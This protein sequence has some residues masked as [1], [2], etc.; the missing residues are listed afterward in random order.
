MF[1]VELKSVGKL[2][3]QYHYSRIKVFLEC[4][5]KGLVAHSCHVL[6][7]SHVQTGVSGAV[8]GAKVQAGARFCTVCAVSIRRPLGMANP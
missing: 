8:S 7:S 6:F 4:T 1:Q 5:E 2:N 3:V